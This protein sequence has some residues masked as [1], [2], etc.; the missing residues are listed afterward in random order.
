MT[1]TLPSNRPATQMTRAHKAAIILIALGPETAR[2]IVSEI[3][4]AHLTAFARAIADLQSVPQQLLHSVAREFLND[5][6]RTGSD[7]VSGVADAR[8]LLAAIAGEERAA[9]ALADPRGPG[10]VFARLEE[11]ESHLLGAY[12]AKQR[13]AVAAVVLGQLSSEKAASVLEAADP[14]FAQS[15]LIELSKQHDIGEESVAAIAAGIES[16]FLVGR[17]VSPSAGA[18][19]NLVTEIVNCLPA[20]TRDAL[21]DRLDKLDAGTAR[22]VRRAIIVFEDLHKRVPE[23]AAPLLIRE[24][25][26]ET[27]LKAVKYGRKNAPDAVRFLFGAISKRMVEQYEEE[28]GA[29]AEVKPVEGEAAQ[30]AIM[31]VLRKLSAAGEVKLAPPPEEPEPLTSR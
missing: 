31:R 21:L 3:S 24:I 12:L 22:T 15:A 29:M 8:K 20:K 10:F 30:R 23:P 28:L 5:V 19:V 9:R 13:P 16:D 14:D 1:G 2:G 25:D 6:E 11:V 4:D 27:L 26:K 17:A 7:L 18:A